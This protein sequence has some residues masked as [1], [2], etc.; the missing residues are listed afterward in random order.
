[1]SRVV[2]GAFRKFARCTAAYV[3]MHISIFSFSAHAQF[4]R[5]TAAS[6]PTTGTAVVGDVLATKTFLDNTGTLVTGTMINRGAFDLTGAYPGAGYVSSLTGL[7]VS[8][9]CST[10]SLLGS[11]GTAGC[12]SGTTAD[13]AAAANIQSGRECWNSS[14]TKITGTLAPTASTICT[15]T[16]IAGVS[17]S[18]VC[19]GAAG[20]GSVAAAGHICS[21]RYLYNASG[22]AVNG[23]RTCYDLQ[24]PSTIA[25]LKLWLRADAIVGKSNAD[26]IDTWVD[27][28]GGGR[29]ATVGFN[30]GYAPT[31][32]TNV[33]NSLPVVR[34]DGSDYLTGPAFSFS[35]ISAFVVAKLNDRT[36]D[37]R[38]I[39]EFGPNTGNGNSWSNLNGFA[40]LVIDAIDDKFHTVFA[41]SAAADS[42]S[43]VSSGTLTA[44]FHLMEVVFGSGTAELFLDGV[45]QGTDTYTDSTISPFRYI[46]GTRWTGG[47]PDGSL[48]PNDYAE[49]ILY[50]DKLS[51]TNRQTIEC[52]LSNKYALGLAGC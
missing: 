41:D 12:I 19:Q 13:A 15:S 50:D 31:Y 6:C 39:F 3:Y 38:S 37:Y 14:G 30:S 34:M 23:S 43:I 25:G 2:F 36:S 26:N 40:L 42:L 27:L 11:A 28:S 44:G 17:G 20:S 47:A 21:G 8:Q 48:T 46:F 9:V 16:T 45:S 18:A 22:V 7:A 51:T 29:H 35:K 1:M 49:I 32:R 4:M 5:T 33:V 52:Y 10:T 24:T